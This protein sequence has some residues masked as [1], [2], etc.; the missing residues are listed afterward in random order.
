MLYRC[1]PYTIGR[2]EEAVT[3]TL[4]CNGPALLAST[5]AW[6]ARN[7]QPFP[8]AVLTLTERGLPL[9]NDVLLGLW[10]RRSWNQRLLELHYDL[11]NGLPLARALRRRLARFLP[12]FFLQGVERAEKDG[13]LAEVLP[14]FAQRLNV[15][16][17]LRRQYRMELLAPVLVL[18][19][20]CGVVSGMQIFIIPKML[21][22]F[23]ELLEG[24]FSHHFVILQTLSAWMP[25]ILGEVVLLLILLWFCR[26]LARLLGRLL[27]EI[28]VWA[29]GFRRQLVRK[30]LLEFAAG[31]AAYL[32][33]GEDLL[34][35]ARFSCR[36]CPQ[37]W[38]RWKLRRW[39]RK[40]EQGVDWQDAWRQMR[41]P[42]PL[43][44]LIV[45]N[46]AARNNLIE[47]FDTAAEWLYHDFLHT[48]NRN[49]LWTA[50]AAVAV[51]GTLVF[52]IGWCFFG[53]LATIV[54]YLAR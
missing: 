53:M 47:G 12:E 37:W 40:M 18:W 9:D 46:A 17:E 31:M 44:N 7:G 41:L 26:P 35:A 14:V 27:G 23:N 1:Q 39:V 42:L 11:S 51:N 25:T 30:A 36:S 21:K 49:L 32:S 5:L 2:Y 33:A 29:P 45:A 43:F 6:A 22:I 50:L 3:G 34:T 13:R 38:L 20:I 54:Q 48:Q 15:A 4:S 24:T 19:L 10:R 8:P 52:L 28:L 16:A